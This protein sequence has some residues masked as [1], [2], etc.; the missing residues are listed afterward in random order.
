MLLSS[1]LEF[2]IFICGKYEWKSWKSDDSNLDRYL[3]L[4]NDAS[5]VRNEVYLERSLVEYQIPGI[6]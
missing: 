5:N 2:N 1:F 4:E 6:S 3:L